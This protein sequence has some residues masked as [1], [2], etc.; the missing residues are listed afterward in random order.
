MDIDS[1][2]YLIRDGRY[3]TTKELDRRINEREF[4]LEQVKEALFTGRVIREEPRQRKGYPKCTI[5]GYT[6]RKV[7]NLKLPGL[8]EL[9][10][11]CAVADDVVIFLTAYWPK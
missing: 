5:R 7:A 6:H 2:R 4:T 3:R 11:G 8:F 9:E 1:I 10:V